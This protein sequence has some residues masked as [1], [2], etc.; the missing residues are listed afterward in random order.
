M[1]ILSSIT[2][3]YSKRNSQTYFE[4]EFVC[5]LPMRTVKTYVSP[6]NRNWRHWASYINNWRPEQTP[7]FQDLPWKTE[8]QGIVNADARP[9]WICNTNLEEFLNIV[10]E[11]GG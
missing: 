8:S 3:R 9:T 2:E 4:L 6:D 11:S 10:I 7:V 1:M 5:G